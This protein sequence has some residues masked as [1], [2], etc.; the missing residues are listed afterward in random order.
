MQ[1]V[2]EQRIKIKSHAAL[3]YEKQKKG[4]NKDWTSTIREDA[5][6]DKIATRM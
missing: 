1:E 6:L 4:R 2:V 3:K 5:I